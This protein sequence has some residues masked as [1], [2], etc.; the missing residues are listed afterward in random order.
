ME[1]F[2]GSSQP[3]KQRRGA[4][5]LMSD[6]VLTT[7]LSGEK[8]STTGVTQG[9]LEL[10]LPLI[11]LIHTKHKNK[12]KS[13]TD[14]TSSFIEEELVHW[15]DKAKYVWLKVDQLP[16]NIVRNGW[17]QRCVGNGNTARRSLSW[18]WCLNVTDKQAL[19]TITLNCVW[20]GLHYFSLCCEIWSIYL[21]RTFK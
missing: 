12:M 13:Q 1:I 16:I 7:T 21:S 2:C 6:K 18:S 20:P 4:P 3:F 8:V 9:N 17:N 14:L 11:L 19:E 15:V 10:N 5:S